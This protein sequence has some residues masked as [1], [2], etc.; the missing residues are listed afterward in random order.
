MSNPGGG[1]GMD[2]GPR[3]RPG[4]GEGIRSGIGLLTAFKDAVEETIQ[5]A[6]ARGDLSPERARQ[7]L[8]D[9]LARAQETVGEVRERLDVVPRRDFDA[10]RA[11]V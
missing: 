6:M 2:E 10:L 4:I 11:E 5:E 7:A 3:R 1:S 8:G 9:A